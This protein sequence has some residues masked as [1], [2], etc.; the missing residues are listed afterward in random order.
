MTQQT[1]LNVSLAVLRNEKMRLERWLEKVDGY[2]AR[3]QAYLSGTPFSETR[4]NSDV[5]N[6]IELW[7]ERVRGNILTLEEAVKNNDAH[8][9]EI[10]GHSLESYKTQET[11]FE[12]A[13]SD[14]NERLKDER[15]SDSVRAILL[16]D[17]LYLL[18]LLD[19]IRY[20]IVEYT[21]VLHEQV[22]SEIEAI[23]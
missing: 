12:K 8:T 2:I 11:D 5:V 18:D 21:R 13:V 6:L 9:I 22:R 19:D 16:N 15:L 20:Y 10:L 17:E 1:N 4:E 3:Y 23:K 14:I 7:H